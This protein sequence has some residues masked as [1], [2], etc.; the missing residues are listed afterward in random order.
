M[1][2]TTKTTGDLLEMRLTGRLD[3]DSSDHLTTAIND[4][5]RQGRHAMTL[6]LSD[7]RYISSAGIGALV[8]AYKQFQS[9]R[10]SFGIVAVS[11]EGAEVIRLTGLAKMLLTDGA[12]KS[13]SA[14][15]ASDSIPVS[16]LHSEHDGIVYEV[17]N[18]HAGA[19]L[20][21]EVIGDPSPL[22]RDQFDSHQCRPVEFPVRTLGL[23][24]GAFGSNFDDCIDQFGEFL[25]VG[26]AATQ[27]PTNGANKPDFQRVLGEFIPSLQALY[28]LKCTGDFSQLIRFNRQ[29]ADQRAKLSQVADQFLKLADTDL[30]AVVLLA[31]SAGLIGATLRRSPAA[32]GSEASSRMAHPEIRQWLSFTPDPAYSHTLAL[33]VGVVARGE[34]SG[35]AKRLAPLLRPLAAG[36][37]LNG[38][39]HA[40]VFSY[41]PFKK[42]KLDLN[43][44]VSALLETEDL[45]AVL[46]LLNDDREITGGGESEFVSGACWVGPISGISP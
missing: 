2:I 30:A 11:P 16:G 10:G 20:T 26:G 5:V 12:R 23:G 29:S 35:D 17:Y 13:G 18:L 32:A 28:G 14:N 19:T 42:R 45:Q 7:V 38:H 9:L 24:L 44:T 46:H 1:Q 15:S 27:Q 43:E 31:E 3:N 40:A 34:L 39:F 8:K 22:S 4:A 36:S 33:V 25:S 21:C 6:D 41:R 37:D